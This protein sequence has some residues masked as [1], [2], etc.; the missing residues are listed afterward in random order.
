M[1]ACGGDA[2]KKHR[3][4]LELALGHADFGGR[5]SRLAGEAELV[6]H[7][8]GVDARVIDRLLQ[9]HAKMKVVDQELC[10]CGC[11]PVRAR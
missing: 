5:Q 3:Q 9:I 10:K 2:A 11:D 7:K 4:F 6:V 1:P 8:F